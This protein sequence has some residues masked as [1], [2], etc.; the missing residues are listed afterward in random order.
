MHQTP[1]SINKRPFFST[2]S[3]FFAIRWNDDNEFAFIKNM[4][5][6]IWIRLGDKG[7]M[8]DTHSHSNAT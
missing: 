2:E 8:I 1:I 3:T 7:E 6:D 5:V 4:F